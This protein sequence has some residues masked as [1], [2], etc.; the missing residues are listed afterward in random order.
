MYWVRSFGRLYREMSFELSS[1]SK[2]L[3]GQLRRWD[4]Y[5]NSG[6]AP[7]LSCGTLDFLA[8]VAILTFEVHLS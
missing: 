1:W 2:G 7:D 8:S 4:L 6:V 3:S 5:S